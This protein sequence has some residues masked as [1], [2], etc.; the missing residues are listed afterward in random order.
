MKFTPS[1]GKVVEAF[2]CVLLIR[3]NREIYST[4]FIPAINE[5]DYRKTWREVFFVY[6]E[7][8]R[9][10]FNLIN[11]FYSKTNY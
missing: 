5:F 3:T 9:K 8:Q 1:K 10:F 11:T 4:N 6:F 7:A 2:P